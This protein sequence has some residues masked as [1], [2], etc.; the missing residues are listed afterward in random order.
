MPGFCHAQSYNNFSQIRD[1][2]SLKNVT[3]QQR[4]LLK[5]KIVI[6]KEN[7][8]VKGKQSQNKLAQ[9]QPTT[10]QLYNNQF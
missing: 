1:L 3:T 7:L 8:C 5:Q 2:L 10:M 6:E 4:N 9:Y